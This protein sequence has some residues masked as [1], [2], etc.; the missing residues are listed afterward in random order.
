MTTLA[1]WAAFITAI[2]HIGSSGYMLY[3]QYQSRTERLFEMSVIGVAAFILVGL[4][5]A[6]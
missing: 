3:S 5:P 4:W 2:I 6:L 1:I